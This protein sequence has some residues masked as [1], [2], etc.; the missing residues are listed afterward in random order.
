MWLER[1][2]EWKEPKLGAE[3]PSCHLHS[4]IFA[5]CVILGKPTYLESLTEFI[6]KLGMIVSIHISHNLQDCLEVWMRSPLPL[7]WE[8]FPSLKLLAPHPSCWLPSLKSFFSIT[9]MFD[10][11][12]T[13][14]FISEIFLLC[15]ISAFSTLGVCC[16]L[17]CK[18]PVTASALSERGRLHNIA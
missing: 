11:V 3:S 12:D 6:C 17:L 13:T 5:G 18:P 1:Q 14:A 2:H 16:F 10:P 4:F 7:P 9:L 15:A 8:P